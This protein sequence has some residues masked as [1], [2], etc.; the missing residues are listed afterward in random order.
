MGQW[1]NWFETDV[2]VVETCSDFVNK[3]E[4]LVRFTFTSGLRSLS[5]WFRIR[6]NQYP[7]RVV[8]D[9]KQK[10]R[11]GLSCVLF[12]ETLSIVKYFVVSTF[13]LFYFVTVPYPLFSPLLFLWFPLFL[14][15]YSTS[16]LPLYVSRLLLS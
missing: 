11:G 1:T 13:F 16:L 2:S 9:V 15:F 6:L 10:T 4:N 14:S 3:N 7:T 12:I 5:L 8:P